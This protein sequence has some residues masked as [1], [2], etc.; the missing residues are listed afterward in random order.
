MTINDLTP[1]TLADATAAPLLSAAGIGRELAR[2]GVHTWT[3]WLGYLSFGGS[4]D[5]PETS[6]ALAGRRLVPASEIYL[7]EQARIC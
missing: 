5:Y 1:P 6:E 3:F 4:M 7:M 2:T